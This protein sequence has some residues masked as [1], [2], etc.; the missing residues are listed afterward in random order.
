MIAVVGKTLSPKTEVI[1][2][3]T[4]NRG[5]LEKKKKHNT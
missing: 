4:S 5:E 3:I 2:G 1:I